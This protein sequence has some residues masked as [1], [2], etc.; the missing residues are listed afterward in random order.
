MRPADST[1]LSGWVLLGPVAEC[2]GLAFQIELCTDS[3]IVYCPAMCMH[4]FVQGVFG[5]GGSGGASFG[6]PHGNS[7][8][9]QSQHYHGNAMQQSL[10]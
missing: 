9:N 7:A 2:A 3:Y 5:G 10:F 4:T 8:S 6:L 1:I